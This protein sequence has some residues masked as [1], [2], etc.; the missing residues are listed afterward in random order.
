MVSKSRGTVKKKEQIL[1]KLWV[2]RRYG[3]FYCLY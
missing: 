3:L 2:S 1:V